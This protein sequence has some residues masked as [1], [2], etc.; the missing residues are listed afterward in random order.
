MLLLPSYSRALRRRVT[1][2]SAAHV[3]PG[4]LPAESQALSSLPLFPKALQLLPTYRSVGEGLAPPGSS[5]THSAMRSVRTRQLRRPAESCVGEFTRRA[6]AGRIKTNIARNS[7]ALNA[8]AAAAAKSV[9]RT[10]VA[11]CS[12]AIMECLPSPAMSCDNGNGTLGARPDVL[13][14]RDLGFKRESTSVWHEPRR[15]QRDADIAP[16]FGRAPNRSYCSSVR[17]TSGQRTGLKPERKMDANRPVALQSLGIR[18]HS[19]LEWR[20]AQ[21]CVSAKSLGYPSIF[22]RPGSSFLRPSPIF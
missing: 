8:T 19:P 18:S 6:V 1:V 5:F 2:R 11:K 17:K 22:I 21:E 3:G 14:T 4:I 13:K 9:V 12:V 20:N 10:S 15:G 16:E 7:S